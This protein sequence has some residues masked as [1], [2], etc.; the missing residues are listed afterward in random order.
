MGIYS[1]IPEVAANVTDYCRGFIQFLES[2]M[3]Q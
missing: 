2:N 3:K 1:S